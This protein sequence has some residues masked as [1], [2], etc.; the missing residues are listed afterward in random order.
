MSKLEI[1]EN[2][3]LVLKNVLIKE[4]KGI[5]ME[6]LNNEINKFL[7]TLKVLKVQTFGPLITKSY[8]T[9]IHEDGTISTNYDL[10]IQAH[11]YLQYKKQFKVEKQLECSHCI[12]LR[13]SD[14]PQYLQYAYS[15]L[16]IYFYENDIESNGVT[17]NVFVSETEDNI[18]VD[19]FKPVVI[20]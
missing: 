6:D 4:L 10:M 7:N 2:K 3:K 1:K 11:N 14:K 13:F 17:Y 19:I 16:D 12:Y 9:N 15:K 20:V 18:V 5:N 8:G